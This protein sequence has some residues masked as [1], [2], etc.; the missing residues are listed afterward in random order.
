MNVMHT[1]KWQSIFTLFAVVLMFASL[2][3]RSETT[4]K[5]RLRELKETRQAEKKEQHN[6]TKPLTPGD[7]TFK[8][9]HQ[10]QTRSY[11]V[12]VP[13]SYSQDQATAMVL[14]LHG[15]GGNMTYQATEKYYHLISASEQAGFIAVFP[16][17]YS[18]LPGGNIATWN[19][20]IC[21]GKARDKDID[22]VG[23]IKQVINDMKIKA[24]IDAKRV[25][26]NGMSN[27][28]MMSYRLACELADS[29]TAIAS[30]AGT[31]GTI[32]CSPSR[33]ISI[34]HIH[35]LDDDHVLFNGGSGVKSETHADFTS[36][37]NTINKWVKLNACH[38]E[39]KRVFEVKGA[40][41]DL[42]SACKNNTQ[43]KL[44]VTETGGHSWPGGT[45]V[46]GGTA[47]STAINAND[48]IWKFYQENTPH[49]L[50]KTG[51]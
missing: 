34:L 19:A 39:P 41:C 37:P 11:M 3:A 7:Y 32:A 44:C 20:G 6:D 51:N 16:N 10:N 47:G 40:Y 8:L 30:V 31:D 26:A 13:T 25:Y 5:E 23:F 36:V 1:Y 18:R 22:D 42:Y 29:I 45:K 14:S 35:A 24:N 28:G 46:R 27:G 12:H 4:F 2:D 50:A 21:C 33:P 49:S 48:L 38:P 9:Q 17:G 43:V 15:G